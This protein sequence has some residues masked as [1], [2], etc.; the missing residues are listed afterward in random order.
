L[1]LGGRQPTYLIPISKGD[2]ALEDLF[3]CYNFVM[4][5]ATTVPVNRL[6]LGDDLEIMKTLESECVFLHRE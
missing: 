6:I 1:P 3:F 4:S 2:K 5:D